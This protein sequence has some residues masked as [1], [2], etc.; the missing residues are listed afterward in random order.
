MKKMMSL[1]LA[2]AMMLSL[3]I[4]AAAAEIPEGPVEISVGG[5]TVTVGGEGSS[6]MPRYGGETVL[7]ITRAANQP[8]DTTFRCL[9]QY[10][11]K[12]AV[13]IVNN[14]G[15][16]LLVQMF[17]GQYAELVAAYGSAEIPIATTDGSPLQ[18]TVDIQI[19]ALGNPSGTY[20]VI[21]VQYNA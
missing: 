13:T 7:N 17:D 6:V 3:A 15:S 21:A 2:L 9:S 20:T 12:C 8:L 1:V 19:E 11:N 18:V 4:S 5:T 16:D 14:S 10:G